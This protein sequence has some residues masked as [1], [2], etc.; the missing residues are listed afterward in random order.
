MAVIIDFI[1]EAVKSPAPKRSKGAPSEKQVDWLERGLDQSGG[2]LPMF[3][4]EG[5]KFSPR[6]IQI[7]IDKGWAVPWFNNPL[8]PDWQ[9]CKLTVAGRQA[10]SLI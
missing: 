9:V 4:S 8:K 1:K 10:I 6:T 3:D 2:K 5:R 7:C